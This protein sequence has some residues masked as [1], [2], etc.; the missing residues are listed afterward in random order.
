LTKIKVSILIF[1]SSWF[2]ID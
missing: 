2:K 1:S